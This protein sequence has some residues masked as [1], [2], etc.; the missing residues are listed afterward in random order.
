MPVG[1]RTVMQ[2]SNAWQEQGFLVIAA[3]NLL[4]KKQCL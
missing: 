2:E 3:F 4:N 1:W